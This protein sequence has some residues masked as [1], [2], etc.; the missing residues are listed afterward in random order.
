MDSLCN[1]V[2]VLKL[3]W[4]IP[5]QELMPQLMATQILE[6]WGLAHNLS[7][8]ILLFH[9][10]YSVTRGRLEPG[11]LGRARSTGLIPDVNYMQSERGQGMLA[12]ASDSSGRSKDKL[13][14]KVIT[15]ISADQQVYVLYCAYCLIC[16]VSFFYFD[17]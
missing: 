7:L 13:D 17:A 3:I 16:F 6:I 9:F 15:F 14:Q 10:L 5:V 12:V 4:L 11:S 1:Q 8:I 2:L